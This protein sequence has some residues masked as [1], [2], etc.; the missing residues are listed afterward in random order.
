[1][2]SVYSNC[3]EKSH[4]ILANPH[5]IKKSKYQKKIS[6]KVSQCLTCE[7]RCKI[8]LGKFG[9]CQTRTNLDGEL[10]T[11]VYGCVPDLASI[12]EIKDSPLLRFLTGP[13]AINPVERKPLYHFHPGTATLTVGTYGCN[14][15]CFWCQNRHI[16]HPKGLISEEATLKGVFLSP[17]HFIK[18]VQKY[19]LSLIHI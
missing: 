11:I 16:S 19:N 1:M 8:S 7:R 14:F 15:D 4:S 13:I 10:Y 2:T 17:E 3:I 9:Y 6:D 18:M 5:F 12:R